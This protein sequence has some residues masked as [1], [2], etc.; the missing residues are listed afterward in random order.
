MTEDHVPRIGVAAVIT[1]DNQLLLIRRKR[2]HG[3]GSW[4]V[5]G[6]H[7]EFGESPAEC[8]IREALEE[9]GLHVNNPRFTALTNEIFESDNK[10]YLTIWMTVD[11]AE[12]EEVIPAEDE[13]AEW[14]WFKYDKLPEPLFLPLQNLVDGRGVIFGGFQAV[15]NSPGV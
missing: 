12:N 15:I 11:C 7:L 14:G 6:G 3:A 10:H 9:V 4:A 13:V 8:A 5:P 2:S 1:M